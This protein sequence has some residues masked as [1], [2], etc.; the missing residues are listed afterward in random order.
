MFEGIKLALREKDA[1]EEFF[2]DIEGGA[3]KEFGT[4][5]L[6]APTASARV[7]LVV[8]KR[9]HLETMRLLRKAFRFH[10]DV[11][12]GNLKDAS[13]WEDN[14]ALQMPLLIPDAMRRLR[15]GVRAEVKARRD[16]ALAWVTPF[17]GIVGVMA[18][19]ILGYF[20]RGG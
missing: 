6:N 5:L 10:L 18:G 20:L 1:L 14:E 13:V 16:A 12:T 11:P 15:E 17:I 9:W 19:T 4:K 7:L 2:K 8:H 3:L